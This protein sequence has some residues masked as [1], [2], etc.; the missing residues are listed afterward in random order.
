[1]WCI[2]AEIQVEGFLHIQYDYDV[3]GI[4]G[5]Q[6]ELTCKVETEINKVI[7]EVKWYKL[8]KDGR[9]SVVYYYEPPRWDTPGLNYYNRVELADDGSSLVIYSL[10]RNDESSYRCDVTVMANETISSEIPQ[11]MSVTMQLAVFV[12]P[13]DIKLSTLSSGNNLTLT[14]RS[15]R[16]KP[17]ADITWIITNGGKS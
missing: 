5:H 10:N 7:K 2:V 17:S 8:M 14:C 16:S 12:P 13:S 3:T 9:K 6:A 11:E 4:Y 1:M 15:T